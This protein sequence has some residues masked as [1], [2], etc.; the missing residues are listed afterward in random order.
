MLGRDLTQKRADKYGV[1][2]FV[3]AVKTILDQSEATAR[4]QIRAIADGDYSYEHFA[5]WPTAT[6]ASMR[7]F[8][9]ITRSHQFPTA[10]AKVVSWPF[11]GIEL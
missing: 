7:R 4:A 6:L 1:Q 11:L 9:T 10:L 3:N 2:T 8:D 5:R